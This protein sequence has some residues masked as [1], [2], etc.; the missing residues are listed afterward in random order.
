MRSEQDR[1]LWRLRAEASAD[2]LARQQ[3]RREAAKPHGD[4]LVRLL[5]DHIGVDLDVLIVTSSRAWANGY[6]LDHDA[7]SVARE[8][9]EVREAVEHRRPLPSASTPR[10]RT[11][12]RL[13]QREI[14][15][16]ESAA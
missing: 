3:A 6:I 15:S 4:D 7:E 8:M 13:V 5:A 11:I 2:A 9:D 1:E 14:Q 12:R 10:E 16:A